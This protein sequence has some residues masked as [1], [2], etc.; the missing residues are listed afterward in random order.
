M[1]IMSAAKMPTVQKGPGRP[2]KSRGR[3][4]VP[5]SEELGNHVGWSNYLSEV[6]IA[7]A[8]G[9]VSYRDVDS[10]CKIARVKNEIDN[11]KELRDKVT[12]LEEALKTVQTKQRKSIAL[13]VVTEDSPDPA[14]SK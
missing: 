11:T 7:A 1:P 13:P 2:K 4:R 14:P 5:S 10:I 9:D 3:L 12:R 6:L 8:S